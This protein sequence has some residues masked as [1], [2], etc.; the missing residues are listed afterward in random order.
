[1]QTI[2][3]NEPCS[4]G[5]GKKYK[6]CC[7][8]KLEVEKAAMAV[9]ADVPLNAPPGTRTIEYKGQRFVVS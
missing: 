9:H 8:G 5:S 7:L 4:C 1:M 3:R 6:K 2:G